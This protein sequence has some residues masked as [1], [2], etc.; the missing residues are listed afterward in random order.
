MR[1][2]Y[3]LRKEKG[4]YLQVWASQGDQIFKCI[5]PTIGSTNLGPVSM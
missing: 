1:M 3:F 4:S 5:S 2:R